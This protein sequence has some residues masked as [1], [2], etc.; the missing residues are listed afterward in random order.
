VRW[1]LGRWGAGV[2]AAGVLALAAGTFLPWL[3]SGSVLRDSYQ[4]IGAV[5][6]VLNVGPV[7][8]AG[9]DAWLAVVPVGSLCIALFALRARRTAAVLT[10][11]L[12]VPAGTVAGLV[13]VQGGD[14][15]A[16]LAA[17]TFGPV[18][19]MVGAGLALAGAIA[20]LA[21]RTDRPTTAGGDS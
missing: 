4:A 19:S 1:V 8:A 5:R 18:V 12:A 6:G 15:D 7:A 16:L 3:R 20:V 10:C 13:A 21:G 14:Q 11:V 2:A 17:A 9:L